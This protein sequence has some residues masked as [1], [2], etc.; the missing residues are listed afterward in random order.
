MNIRSVCLNS[1]SERLLSDWLPSM[2]QT[3]HY[4][5][6]AIHLIGQI[7]TA[8]V[9]RSDCLSRFRSVVAPLRPKP[10]AAEAKV[11]VKIE[12]IK[13]QT[14]TSLWSE[15]SKVQP[16]HSAAVWMGD[17]DAAA[18]ASPWD[19]KP[20]RHVRDLLSRKQTSRCSSP[21]ASTT[22]GSLQPQEVEVDLAG[23][24]ASTFSIS[25]IS[26]SSISGERNVS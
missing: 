24:P 14:R 16:H 13:S 11:R 1:K 10:V 15:R 4:N 18:D 19:A 17:E 5:F 26:M 2:W 21:L 20:Q 23:L 3:V 9:H 8:P 6:K 25:F 22:R 7:K 12:T